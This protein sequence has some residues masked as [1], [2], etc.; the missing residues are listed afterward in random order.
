[1]RFN[2]IYNEEITRPTTNPADAL[3]RSRNIMDAKHPI[4]PQMTPE[5][6]AVWDDQTPEATAARKKW[7]RENNVRPQ[8][9]RPPAGWRFEAGGIGN[10]DGDYGSRRQGQAIRPPGWT[11]HAPSAAGGLR[12]RRRSDETAQ[13]PDAHLPE[14]IACQRRLHR[15]QGQHRPEP[16]T[17]RAALAGDQRTTAALR[18][19]GRG[20]VPERRGRGRARRHRLW[21]GE[22]GATGRGGAAHRALPAP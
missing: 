5:V 17:D 19:A 11:H 13:P 7:G 20:A 16:D 21:R 12:S 2:T 14:R 8:S 10:A 18:Q 6:A 22:T 3:E 15:S 9:P 4:V 1:M